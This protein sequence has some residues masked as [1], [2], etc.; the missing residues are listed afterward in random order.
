[1]DNLS[2]LYRKCGQRL[3]LDVESRE[4]YDTK[5]GLDGRSENSILNFHFFSRSFDWIGL[6]LNP[7]L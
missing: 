2:S 3:I 5:W 7:V 4:K 6:K 1:M